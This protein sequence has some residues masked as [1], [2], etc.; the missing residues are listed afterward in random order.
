[1]SNSVM[2]SKRSPPKQP[3]KRGPGAGSGRTRSTLHGREGGEGR[4]RERQ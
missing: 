4:D 1:M 2:K 3:D